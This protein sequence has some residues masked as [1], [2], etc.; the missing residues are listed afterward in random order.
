MPPEDGQVGAGPSG[1]LRNKGDPIAGRSC[2]HS[3][4]RSNEMGMAYPAGREKNEKMR[5]KRKMLEGGLLENA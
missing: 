5:K 3:I 1:D 4:S 2:L